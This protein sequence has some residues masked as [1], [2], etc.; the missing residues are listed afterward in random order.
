MKLRHK[1]VKPVSFYGFVVTTFVILLAACGGGRSSSDPAS[2]SGSGAVHF[3]IAYQNQARNLASH[4]VL[5]CTGLGIATIE[6]GVYDQN[7]RLLGSGGPWACLDGEGTVSNI[8]AGDNRSVVVRGMSSSGDVVLRGASPGITIRAGQSNSAGTIT[9]QPFVPTPLFPADGTVVDADDISLGWNPVQDAAGYDIVISTNSDLSNPVV[10]VGITDTTYTATGLSNGTTY[11]WQVSA[12]DA[13]GNQGTGSQ[14]QTMDARAWLSVA[15][16]FDHTLAISPGGTLWTWGSNGSGQLGL[17]DTDD[18]HRPTQVGTDTDWASVAAGGV[19]S[20]AIKANGELWAWGDNAY[21]QLGLGD[22]SDRLSPTRVGTDID[23]ASVAAGGS[24]TLAIKTNRE[25]WAWGHNIDGQ[26]GIGNFVGQTSPAQIGT[27]R[28]W[29]SATAGLSHSLA[30]KYN[31]DNT[32][33]TLWG[34]GYNADCQLGLGDP[35][36]RN[37]PNQVGADTDW[38]SA[39]AGGSHTLALKTNGTLW[40]WGHNSSG[41][42]GI[43][44]SDPANHQCI[45]F[46]VDSDSNWASVASGYHYSL[47]IKN[48]G[49][50]WVCGDN[51]VGQLG[52]G[53]TTNQLTWTRIGTETD[54][55]FIAG[56]RHTVAVKSDGTLWA[57]G[58]NN[59]GQLGSGTAGSKIR[60]AQVGTDTDWASAAAGSRHTL[61]I[62]TNGQLWTAGDNFYGQLGDGTTNDCDTLAQIGTQTDWETVSGG[63]SHSVATETDGTLWVWG[64]NGYGQ[65]GLGDTSDRLAPSALSNSYFMATGSNHTVAIR[66][67]DTL[68]AWGHNGYGQ[69]GVG[70]PDNR[71]SPTQESSNS[72]SWSSVAVGNYHT[73]A[74]KFD[75]TLWAWG[76]NMDGQLGFGSIDPGTYS[77]IQVGNDTDWFSV[78][79]GN[80]HTVAIK[81]NGTLWAWGNNSSG[82]LGTGIPSANEFSPRRIL[83]INYVAVIAAG[84]YHTV[85]LGTAGELW[86]WGDNDYGQLGVGD[87]TDRSVPT[88]VGINQ[89]WASVACGANFTLAVTTDGELWAWGDN[90][91]GQH[92]DGTAWPTRPIHIQRAAGITVP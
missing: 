50:L 24:H 34:W 12:R 56:G 33:G 48:N 38:E 70:A 31:D 11:H 72:T 74:I 77:P 81:T 89:N 10:D 61:A 51:Q 32:L 64:D 20:L 68:W 14:I 16:G 65:L 42:L 9:C 23:W 76:D 45:P 29:A 67:D 7:D 28:D 37:T 35:A 13:Q 66:S 71:T 41:Q 2:D 91:Y 69:L 63:S 5:D 18:R 44:D 58:Y 59:W 19:F 90:T 46:L 36:S 17:G 22:T 39:V 62:K 92:G 88:R 27:D 75:G 4:A 21:G 43:E 15:T 87:T 79:A 86:A 8:P 84:N 49:E 52:L 85:A 26:L 78:A 60:P 82:Q 1:K 47:A 55:E 30:V 80:D 40:V 6:V 25:I 73:V 57:W 54:W 53:H 83:G 3:N